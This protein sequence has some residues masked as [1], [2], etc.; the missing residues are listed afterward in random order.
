MKSAVSFKD[1]WSAELAAGFD[2]L[3][4]SLGPE[5][6]SLL[7]D[8]L[9]LL[10]RWNKVYNLTAVRDPQVMVRRQLLD[11]LSILPWLNA[12][13]VLDVG[14]GAGLPGI[15][16]AIARP[17]LAFSLLDSNGKKTRFVQQVVSELG[18]RNVE[19]LKSRIEALQRPGHYACI[20]S[21][22]FATLADMIDGSRQLITAEGRWLAMKGAAPM[23]ELRELPPGFT[24]EVVPLEVPGEIGSRHLVIVERAA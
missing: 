24:A 19:V 20:T 12:G 1:V 16:L 11:S 7:I 10:A 14:T 23:A 2:A 13:P 21:R 4:L 6:Q 22:A 5:Q 3:S 18:L 17:E 9:D 8:Y 15:P